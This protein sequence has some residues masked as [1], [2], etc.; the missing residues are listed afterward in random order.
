M[1]DQR[2]IRKKTAI[3]QAH[4][5]TRIIHLIGITGIKKAVDGPTIGGYYLMAG[6]RQ[7]VN[8][9]QEMSTYF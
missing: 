3:S 4:S 7:R 1:L 9:E 8:I 5:E 2:D 6:K